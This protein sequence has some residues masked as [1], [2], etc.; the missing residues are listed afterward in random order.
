MTGDMGDWAFDQAMKQE[1]E[2]DEIELDCT[3]TDEEKEALS[4]LLL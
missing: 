1:L 3:L 4:D 2:E